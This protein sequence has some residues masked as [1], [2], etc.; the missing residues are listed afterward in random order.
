MTLLPLVLEMKK[1]LGH[2]NGWID[3]AEAHAG[4]KTYDANTLLQGR[5]APDML[6]L[7]RQFQNACDNRQVRRGVHHRQGAALTPGYRANLC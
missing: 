2:M 1:L 3:K 6:P 4:S 5:L 7:V